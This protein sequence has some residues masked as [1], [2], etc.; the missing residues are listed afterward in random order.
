MVSSA[1]ESDDFDHVAVSEGLG[2]ELVARD[3]ATVVLDGDALDDH[4]DVFEQS[5][6]GEPVGDATGLSVKCY[7]QASSPSISA[8]T[9][10]RTAS[11]RASRL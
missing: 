11:A 1:Y 10:K 4:A 3:D 2:G 6:Q 5:R 8:P 7:S 9:W